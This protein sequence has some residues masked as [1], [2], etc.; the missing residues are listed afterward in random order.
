MILIFSITSSC[1]YSAHTGIQGSSNPPSSGS[2]GI[3]GSGGN[4]G[5]G[6]NGTGGTTV[7]TWAEIVTDF[8]RCP[9]LEEKSSIDRDFDIQFLDA[10]TDS[11]HWS[12]VPDEC[13]FPHSGPTRSKIYNLIRF[14]RNLSFSRPLPFT[15]NASLYNFLSLRTVTDAQNKLQLRL[16]LPCDLFSAGGGFGINFNG[17][18]SRWY[19]VSGSTP[20][21]ELGSITGLDSVLI[22]HFIYHPLYA[23]ELLVHEGYHAIQGAPH[24]GSNGSDATIQEMGAWAA[25]FYFNAWITLYATNVDDRTRQLARE[26]A[27]SILESRFTNNQCPEDNSLKAVVNQISPDTCR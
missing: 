24:T 18:M 6:G 5:T 27:A 8:I 11:L 19:P 12:D 16:Y 10:S 3:S 21:C 17:Y 1:T 2:G 13:T 4:S 23:A 14:I 22:N 25:Q 9:T 26:N 15:S 20:H 7:P